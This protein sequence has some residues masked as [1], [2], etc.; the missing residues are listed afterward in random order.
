MASLA[1]TSE[2]VFPQARGRTNGVGNLYREVWNIISGLLYQ[3]WYIL[4]DVAAPREEVGQ[5]NHMCAAP[6]RT[7][8]YRLCDGGLS[9][10][11]MRNLYHLV[12]C[13]LPKQCCKL[14]ESFI[15][16]RAPATMIH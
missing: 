2:E 6:P 3:L 16:S 12:G 10:F 11:H 4:T 15:C 9:E 5:H 1:V 7:P 14:L 13:C 8:F